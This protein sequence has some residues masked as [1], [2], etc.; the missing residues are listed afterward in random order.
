MEEPERGI[1]SNSQNCSSGPCSSYSA[2]GRFFQRTSAFD[3]MHPSQS[4]GVGLAPPHTGFGYSAYPG[5]WGFMHGP[6]YTPS[7]NFNRALNT[8]SNFYSVSRDFGTSLGHTVSG[9]PPLIGA[10]ASS[11]GISCEPVDNYGTVLCGESPCSPS[12]SDNC[13][14]DDLDKKENKGQDNDPYKLD[15]SVKPRKERTAFTKHQIRE[16]E[17]E[18][19]VH[20]YLTRLRRYEIAV[21]LDLTERQV[22]VWFQNRRMKWKRVKGTKLVKDKVDGQLKPIMA[23]NVSSTA[24]DVQNCEVPQS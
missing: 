6:S 9:P 4:G 24:S 16:L 22:K 10:S 23:P 1:N 15:L 8:P 11:V 5:D 13:L 19:A 20:N 21:A 7:F 12:S 14:S 3:C 18:F 17:K 2:M